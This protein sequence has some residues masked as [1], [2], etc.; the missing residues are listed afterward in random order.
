MLRQQLQDPQ[1]PEAIKA[2][3]MVTGMV[4][5]VMGVESGSGDFL[6]RSVCFPG[7]PPIASP[8][9]QVFL[10]FSFCS[11]SPFYFPFTLLNHSIQ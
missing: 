9:P 11:T 5:G 10:I 4:I 6:V 7:I 1:H 3:K 8:F 2:E